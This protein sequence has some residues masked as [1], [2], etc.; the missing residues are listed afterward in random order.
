MWFPECEVHPQAEAIRKKFTT[1]IVE[2]KSLK[3]QSS[4]TPISH[5]YTVEIL[6]GQ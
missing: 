1:K 6:S 4:N 2:K 3:T 5:Y